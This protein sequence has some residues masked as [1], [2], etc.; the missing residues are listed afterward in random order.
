M[1]SHFKDLVR[2]QYSRQAPLYAKSRPHALGDTLQL[3][4]SW[5]EGKGTEQVLD[6]AT[7]CGFCAFALAPVVARVVGLDLTP[8]ML[9]EASRLAEERGL[10]NVEFQEGDAEALPFPDAH[11]DIVTCRISAHHF[12]S[13][14]AF[15]SEAWRVLV[16]GGSLLLADTSSP[17]ELVA[18]WH[19][20]IERLRDP[21]HV[22]NLTPAQWRGLVGRAGFAIAEFSADCR[23]QLDFSDW[24]KT[25]GCTPETIS[26]L[27]RGF[28]QAPPEV[29]RAFHIRAN[30]TK[31]LFSWPI[32]AVKA[33]K[34]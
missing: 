17:D 27:L 28:E 25:S 24:V 3:L 5:A 13:P 26:T 15:L 6:V 9:R 20:D 32:T 18:C 33:I 8:H 22:Q 19:N 12:S 2:G 21:S 7:G 10:R 34:P 4:A 1:K 30:G 14:E 31:I 11:F 16:P 23:T 29:K